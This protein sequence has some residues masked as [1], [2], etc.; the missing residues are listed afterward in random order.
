MKWTKRLKWLRL[1]KII[2]PIALAISLVFAG[3]SVYANEA[4][5]F[6]V[7]TDGDRDIKLSLSLEKNYETG[8]LIDPTTNLYIPASGEYNNIGFVPDPECLY[9]E[10][11][12]ML[13]IPDDIALY[14]GMHNGYNVFGDVTFLS[15]SFFLKN[16]SERAVDVDMYM[17][18]DGLT[19]AA[20]N[21]SDSHVDD[22]IKI[23][24]IEG[25]P[26]L[27]DETYTIYSKVESSA[28][29]EKWLYDDITWEDKIVNFGVDDNDYIFKREGELGYKSM[30]PGEVKK[31]T[32]VI[33]L[34][35]EDYDCN[36]NILGERMK[37]SIDFVGS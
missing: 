18:I 37:M 24:F 7:R 21:D 26:L 19:Y 1:S 32:F 3:F 14:D 15:F 9:D 33:W 36:D 8:E 4:E 29:N 31:F 13:N 12:R 27:S 28:A 20:G 5:N 17:N 35:G 34:E 10:S 22:A 2:I 6:V 30:K 25:T 16:N 11:G 23:M